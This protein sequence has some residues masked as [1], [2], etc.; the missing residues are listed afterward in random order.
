[1]QRRT[2][3]E[4]VSE[5][6]SSGGEAVDP[7]RGWEDFRETLPAIEGLN[8]PDS[9]HALNRFG[10]Q[11]DDHGFPVPFASMPEDGDVERWRTEYDWPN[12]TPVVARDVTPGH[13][14][15]SDLTM[16]V[17][18]I[19]VVDSQVGGNT[20]RAIFRVTKEFLYGSAYAG[21]GAQWRNGSWT[22]GPMGRRALAFKWFLS[23]VASIEVQRTHKMFRLRDAE[24][25]IRGETPPP[26]AK[27]EKAGV[28]VSDWLRGAQ[29]EA[30]TEVASSY[31]RFAGLGLHSVPAPPSGESEFRGFAEY[32]AGLV[33]AAKERTPRWEVERSGKNEL[34]VA[35][36]V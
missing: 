5:Q 14:S 7:V 21:F 29:P 13:V 11:I 27:G 25:T 12:F 33:A 19:T 4:G 22:L 20:S 36:F 35:T 30:V 26:G 15:V 10:F 23:D 16:S 24:V 18:G 31:M 9:G 8:N 2:G 6:L 32:L 3:E 17:H 34:H 28:S 1:M